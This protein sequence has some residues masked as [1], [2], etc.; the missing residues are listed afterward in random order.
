VEP[1][2]RFEAGDRLR[3]TGALLED[4]LGRAPAQLEQTHQAEGDDRDGEQ[5]WDDR[6]DPDEDVPEHAGYPAPEFTERSTARSAVHPDALW[7]IVQR[8]AGDALDAGH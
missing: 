8:D 4:L 6:R 1:E 7:P 5:Q 3:I 2:R